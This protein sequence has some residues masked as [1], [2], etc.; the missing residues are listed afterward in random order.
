M[1]TIKAGKGFFL[2]H[3]G[4]SQP[5]LLHGPTHAEYKN[6]HNN[7]LDAHF[8]VVC[9]VA[10]TLALGILKLMHMTYLR[11]GKSVRSPWGAPCI[12]LLALGTGTFLAPLLAGA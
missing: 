11:F 7:T 6:L 12:V 3:P 10:I 4:F 9:A 1:E 2:S 8:P 5:E